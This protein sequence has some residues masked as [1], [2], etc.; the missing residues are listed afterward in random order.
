M[1]L[2]QNGH[3]AD[4]F[5]M[6]F[7]K[8]TFGNLLYTLLKFNPHHHISNKSILV[9]VKAWRLT[10]ADHY[11]NQCW[12]RYLKESLGHKELTHWGRDICVGD[13]HHCFRW[14]LV[15][16]SAPSHY[17]NQCWNI[18]NWILRN[19]LQWNFNP[20]ANIFIR[21]NAFESVVCEMAAILSRLQCV[22]TYLFKAV[23]VYKQ[24]FR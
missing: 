13:N 22:K 11:R 6:H 5:A 20:N 7:V 21:E 15:T 24:W 10:G 17:L 12:P 1:R 9:R 4:I 14:F 18:I 3:F 16:W 19:K 2:E 23:L 8:K